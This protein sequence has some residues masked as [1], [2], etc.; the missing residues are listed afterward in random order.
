LR[1]RGRE[2]RLRVFVRHGGDG[3]V[4]ELL[5][6]GAHVVHST[7]SRRHAPPLRARAAALRGLDFSYTDARERDELL[8]AITPKTR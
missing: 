4:L 1:R 7:T 5:S 8:A 2:E 6:S 3:D